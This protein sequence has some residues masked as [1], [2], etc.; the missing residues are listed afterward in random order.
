MLIRRLY[1]F[2]AA[3]ALKAAIRGAQSVDED[4]TIEEE[5]GFMLIA[6]AVYSLQHLREAYTASK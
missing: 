2:A 1:P 4:M 3:Q 5:V 6:D